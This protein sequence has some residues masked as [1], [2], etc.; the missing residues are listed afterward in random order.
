MG[1]GE[2]GKEA[3]AVIYQ[4]GFRWWLGE[5]GTIERPGVEWALKVSLH[6]S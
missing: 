6:S 1:V 4:I 3:F 5:M 2:E